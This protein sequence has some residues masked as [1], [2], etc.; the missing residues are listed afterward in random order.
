M[1]RPGCIS[2]LAAKAALVAVSL[3]GCVMSRAPGG[4]ITGSISNASPNDLRAQ[5][6]QLGQ[7]YSSNPGERAVSLNYARVLRALEQHPQSVA[8]LQN[9]A[10]RNPNDAEILGLYGRALAD[11]GKLREA[12]QV[13]G[14]AH[15]QDKPDWRILNVQ[16]AVADQLGEHG[17]AHQFYLQALQIAPGEPSVLSNYGLSLALTKKLPEAEQTL[18][19]AAQHPRA[20]TRVR[21]NLALVLALQG[22]FSEAEDVARRDL[23]PQEAAQNVAYVRAMMTQ[24]NSWNQLKSLEKKSGKAAARK[25]PKAAPAPETVQSDT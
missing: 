12:L 4:D 10:I 23:P 15:S 20:V 16:G 17:Q 1:L 22:K 13:L 9:A 5:S 14:S 18:R 6:E 24:Q 25:P 3:G 2:L 21:A 19:Q 8:V 7:R 11:A